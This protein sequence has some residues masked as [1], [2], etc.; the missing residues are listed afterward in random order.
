MSLIYRLC[1]FLFLLAAGT[2]LAQ[3]EE[4]TLIKHIEY[5]DSRERIRSVSLYYEENIHTRP[6]RTPEKLHAMLAECYRISEKK[7]DRE[8]KDYLNFYKNTNTIMFLSES[9]M[10][11]R[12]T[13]TLKVWRE[14][15]KHYESLGAE[16]FVAICHV[17]IGYSLFMLNKYAESL[18]ELLVADEK[19]RKIGYEKFPDIG[20][21]IHTMSLVFYFFRQYEKVAE[22]MEISAKLPVFDSNRH[23]QLY[24]TLG[25][26]YMHLKKYGKAEKAFMKTG[27]IAKAYKDY[28]WMAYASQNLAKLYAEKGEY[29]KALQLYKSN[30]KFLE[31]YKNINKSE[32]YDY[33]L[34]EAKVYLLL[35]NPVKANQILQTINYQPKSNTKDQMFMFGR[36]YQD[37]SY[38][39]NFYD[40]KSKYSLA[41]KNYKNAYYYS[42]SLNSLKY[43]ADSLFNGLEV[44]VAQN[45]IDIK[46]KQY[47]N[48]RKEATIKS[49][50]KQMLLIGILLGVIIMASVLL[51]IQNKKINSRNRIINKQLEELSK[52]LNQKQVL[53]SELQH[54]VKNNLQHVISIL[55]IQKESVDFNNIDEL[56][57]GNQNRIHSMALL[58]KKLNVLDTANEVELKRYITELSELVKESYDNHKKK[59]NLNIQCDIEKISIEKALPLGLMIT[60]LVSNSM[61][62]AFKKRNIGIIN[63]EITKEEQTGNNIL[64]YSD[65]GD[66]FD[67]NKTNDKG[68]GQEIIKGLI[69]QLN[70]TVEANRNNGFELSIH[71]K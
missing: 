71:F 44:K 59:V 7:H 45:R 51:I 40:V 62:H 31:L 35:N 50:N 68:L 25:S 2:L 49:K 28:F 3:E 8:F 22:L 11:I 63:I 65:N 14:T 1:V 4:Q 42:D 19:F 9:D 36:S 16:H 39:L 53:L 43:K 41:I 66:G 47:Q 5:A 26:T 70:G 13:K 46:N 58:H 37:V 12:E 21:H 61:K 27:K 34:G 38:W 6:T 55:E 32:Y 15:L 33:L 23:I 52:T 10:L 24:N 54:R 20:K 48:D 29:A 67:F 18:E 56:I 60:E 30:L 17:N 64:Y 69:D 57:R